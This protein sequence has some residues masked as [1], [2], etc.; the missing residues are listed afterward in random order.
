MNL[1]QSFDTYLQH[2]REQAYNLF[3]DEKNLRFF[4]SALIIFIFLIAIM[5]TVNISSVEYVNTS[6][7]IAILNLAVLL[8]L[9]IFYKKYFNTGNIR[10]SVYIF[11]IAQMLVFISFDIF[12][13]QE[14][15]E[16][17][18]DN[19]NKTEE[20]VKQDSSNLN[21][22]V[23]IGEE[24]D[25]FFEYIVF[26]GILVLIF[27]FSRTE[28]VQ[29]FMI[30]L[31]LPIILLIVFQNAIEPGEFIPN[32]L[33]GT[34][35]FFIAYSSERKRQK[36]FF[37]QYNFHYKKNFESIRMKKELNYARE[38]QLS[39]L[40]ENDAVIGH[41]KISGI[42]NPASEVGGDYF[43]YFKISENETGF[44]ICDVSGHG[45]ASGLLLS[46]LRSGMHLLLEDNSNPKLIMEKLN[47]MIRKTQNRKMFVTSIFAIIDTEKNKCRLFN[48]G[49]LPPYKISGES[50]EIFKIKKHGIALG[51]MD[52]VD[53]SSEDNEVVIDF[54][55]DDKLI[56]YTDGVNEAM[57]SINT[58]YGLDNLEYYLNNNSEKDSTALLNGLLGDIKKFTGD[59]IQKDD[60]TVLIIQ[61]I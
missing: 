33:I 34:F 8:T 5:A 3:L 57:N 26:T 38:I 48:A 45:V 13:P 59:S 35:L 56:F 55:K 41:I 46:G 40:P 29:L 12:Y 7:I 49:H 2:P 61:R 60:L 17:L 9:R 4:K 15:S 44:F 50:R 24:D 30:S 42:S 10:R 52:A 32:I 22:G 1:L 53:N 23:R 6:F 19:K 28:I 37:S 14:E 58:E 31:T 27:S 21:F 18:S 36:N 11:V 16:K 20:V 39:M 51:A 47:R 54:K 25:T 43:D